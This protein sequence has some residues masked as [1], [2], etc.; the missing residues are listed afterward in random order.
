MAP[1]GKSMRKLALIMFG[2]GFLIGGIHGAEPEEKAYL[3]VSVRD[4]ERAEDG[5]IVL[6]V[7]P[8]SPAQAAGLR[9]GDRI[10]TSD[11]DRVCGVECFG[12]RIRAA[13]PGA[14]IVIRFIRNGSPREVQA[15][16]GQ[17]PV[18]PF[19]GLEGR[20]K[21][22]EVLLRDRVEAILEEVPEAPQPPA[23]F[24]SPTSRI[25]LDLIHV[26]PELRRHLGGPFD[27]GMLVGQVKAGS[28]AERA[29]IEAGDLLVGVEGQPV[30]GGDSWVILMN[31]LERPDCKV[32][33]IRDGKPR[34]VTVDLPYR[35]VSRP[36]TPHWPT[37]G[38]ERS[39]TLEKALQDLESSLKSQDQRFN[40]L[41]IILFQ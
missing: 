9:A 17:A 7:V 28:A 36:V 35:T 30:R 40:S 32:D 2:I 12:T 29:G 27:A 18:V 41:N 39:R 6:S 31:T 38:E 19:P 20:F 15:L 14:R 16:L 11:G 22:P 26:T 3:G 8:G 4:L 13:G 5:V 34:A 1:D 33:L 25:G 10:V 23:L 37:W 21:A 24:V